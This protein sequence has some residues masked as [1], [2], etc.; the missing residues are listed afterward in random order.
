MLCDTGTAGGTDQ[1]WFCF[2]HDG[3]V[4]HALPFELPRHEWLLAAA[5][6][7]LILFT[8]HLRL[9]HEGEAQG[10]CKLNVFLSPW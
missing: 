4:H 2:I 6:Q 1:Y 7:S 9:T 10:V 5:V 8:P 3:Y